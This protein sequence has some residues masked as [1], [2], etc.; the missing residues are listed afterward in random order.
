MEKIVFQVI[1]A[2]FACYAIPFLAA[3]F[4]WPRSY[5]AMVDR[6]GM[7]DEQQIVRR[8]WWWA[9]TFALW[10]G[11]FVLTYHAAYGLFGWVPEFWGGY[12]EEG[13]WRSVRT[14][15]QIAI[16]VVGVIGMHYAGANA[17]RA[18]RQPLNAALIETAIKELERVYPE[19]TSDELRQ[20]ILE[21]LEWT[22]ER[23]QDRTMTGHAGLRAHVTSVCSWAKER[24]QTARNP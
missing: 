21:K 19:E 23:S 8:W 22:I 6:M 24:A 11:T 13:E 18:A 3:Q 14:W 16:G 5:A 10:I 17:E 12:G 1:Q 20:R 9:R 7:P 2:L 4:V 15:A